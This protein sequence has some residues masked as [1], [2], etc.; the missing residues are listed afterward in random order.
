M[1]KDDLLYQ[2]HQYYGFF[3]NHESNGG[4]VF[5]NLDEIWAT[6]IVHD[7]YKYD[8]STELY[9]YYELIGQ[10]AFNKVFRAKFKPTGEIIAVKILKIGNET[11]DMKMLR[12]LTK[13]EASLLSQLSHEN[14]IKVRHLI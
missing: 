14:I 7:K 11:H 3:S 5:Y 10:G 1:S 12:E 9:D 8:N 6:N 2:K 4:Q 13:Q